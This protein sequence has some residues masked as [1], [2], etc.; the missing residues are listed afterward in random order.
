MSILMN[1]AIF[2][3]DAGES[4][5]E[6]VAKVIALVRASG[7]P[8]KLGAM[9]TTVETETIGQALALVEQSHELLAEYAQRIYVTT[10]IDSR[11]GALGRLSK[12]VEA[13]EHEI[14]D[15]SK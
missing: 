3:T 13:I 1:F 11:K 10:T 5:H 7:Y 12:K 14:G 15:V 2:P 6:H 9:G 8:Y 4:V